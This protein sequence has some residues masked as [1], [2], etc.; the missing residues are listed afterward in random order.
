MEIKGEIERESWR[1]GERVRQRELGRDIGR[2]G[3]REMGSEIN[4]DVK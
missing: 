4:D 2:K 1:K 3:E